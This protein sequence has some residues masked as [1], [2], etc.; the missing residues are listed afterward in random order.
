MQA[1]TVPHPANRRL[2]DKDTENFNRN[3]GI[4][5][6]EVTQK[7]EIILLGRPSRMI[8]IPYRNNDYSATTS[9]LNSPLMSL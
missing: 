2:E 5:T 8:C 6:K 7:E 3:R 9:N 1:K 4:N